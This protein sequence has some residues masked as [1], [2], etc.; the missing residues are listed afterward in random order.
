MPPRSPTPW[1]GSPAARRGRWTTCSPS[2]RPPFQPLAVTHPAP[3]RAGRKS[4]R[5]VSLSPAEMYRV[6]ADPADGRAGPGQDVRKPVS[7]VRVPSGQQ[8]ASIVHG[9]R[10]A[11]RGQVAADGQVN[12]LIVGGSGGVVGHQP[13]AGP[14]G[15]PPPVVSPGLGDL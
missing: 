15:D 3:D 4:K 12:R 10:P 9:Q 6:V 11:G 14:A 1:S 5:R 7:L 13:R 8:A 2:S